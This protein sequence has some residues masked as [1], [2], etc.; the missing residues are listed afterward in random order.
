[1]LR[2]AGAP[3]LSTARTSEMTLMTGPT[4]H[5]WAHQAWS[6]PASPMQEVNVEPWMPKGGSGSAD[7]VFYLPEHRVFLLRDPKTPRGG[8]L[9]WITRF[10]A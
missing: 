5:H 1:M 9:A 8:G 7:W 4:W 3:N 6:P 2:A 10:D